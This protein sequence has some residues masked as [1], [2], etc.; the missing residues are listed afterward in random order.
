MNDSSYDSE[1][2]RINPRLE[3]EIQDRERRIQELLRKAAGV[4][5]GM[6]DD[7]GNFDISFEFI[8]K[9]NCNGPIVS[10][11][12]KMVYPSHFNNQ[13]PLPNP[14]AVTLEIQGNRLIEKDDSQKY[15]DANR[16][17]QIPVKL[18]SV[19]S[20]RTQ[21]I[22]LE[23]RSSGPLIGSK[24]ATSSTHSI[25]SKTPSSSTH[26]IGS[27]TAEAPSFKVSPITLTIDHNGNEELRE[28]GDGRISVRAKPIP[29][30]SL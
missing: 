2:A 20:R 8:D 13:K 29:T 16:K 9:A 30:T 11:S 10:T 7:P 19:K 26:S 22:T 15:L 23:L 12:K 17:Q 24:S 5:A 25:G 14:E 4:P 28:T 3:R 1:C 27:V 18:S 6:E 21:N